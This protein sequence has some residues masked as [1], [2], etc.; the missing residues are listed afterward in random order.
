MTVQLQHDFPVSEIMGV[1]GILFVCSFLCLSNAGSDSLHVD[2]ALMGSGFPVILT[3]K[4]GTVL[5]FEDCYLGEQTQV[6][7]T[8]KNESEI[9][10]LMFRFRKIAHFSVSPARGKLQKNSEKV[11][12]YFS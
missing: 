10:P 2:L 12:P 3:F 6:V 7:C 5:N 9:L 11:T 1:R 4:P 8:M